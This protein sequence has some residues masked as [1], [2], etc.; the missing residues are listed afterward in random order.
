[1]IVGISANT[2]DRMAVEAEESGMD[3]FMNKPYNMEE[4]EAAYTVI[5]EHRRRGGRA[6][7]GA[8]VDDVGERA[9]REAVSLTAN[10]TLFLEALH[11]GDSGG[12]FVPGEYLASAGGDGDN[13]DGEAVVM[14]TEKSMAASRSVSVRSERDMLSLKSG[15][16]SVDGRDDGSPKPSPSPPSS[17]G[18]Q[19]GWGSAKVHIDDDDDDNIQAAQVLAP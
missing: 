5:C 9:P 18:V 8:G 14:D 7:A 17:D 6:G 10:T 12:I 1:M 13:G 16:S 15:S 4:L 19:R 3:A 2:A 11:D